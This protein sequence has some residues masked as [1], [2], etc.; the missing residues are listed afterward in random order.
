M[1]V[2]FVTGIGIGL[3]VFSNMVMLTVYFNDKLAL[4]S[5]LCMVG[6]G[7]GQIILP[8][9]FNYLLSVLDAR[10]AFLVLGASML[11]VLIGAALQRPQSYYMSIGSN[12]S[13]FTKPSPTKTNVMMCG[14][15]RH[16]GTDAIYDLGQAGS[17]TFTDS[18]RSTHLHLVDMA[19][20]PN[21]V[22][23]SSAV[24]E[25][26]R[27]L[28][29]ANNTCDVS[30][31]VTDGRITGTNKIGPMPINVNRQKSELTLSVVCLP[32]NTD[33]HEIPISTTSG[34]PNNIIIEERKSQPFPIASPPT[35]KEATCRMCSASTFP[36]FILARVMTF[37]SYMM[38]VFFLA[39]YASGEGL[40]TTQINLVL[41]A[42]GAVD[43][44]SRPLHGLLVSF[45]HI[46]SSLFVGCVVL[47][48]GAINGKYYVQSGTPQCTYIYCPVTYATSK[49]GTC[50]DVS[51]IL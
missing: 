7:I 30:E 29:A 34:K 6:S 39:P 31:T 8:Y 10:G 5:G 18:C 16:D 41:T 1:Q 20:V 42:F 49:L 47:V 33:G 51:M 11:H 9:W 15:K 23:A 3:L 48:A 14:T 35:F 28:I 13:T 4:V 17:F 27:E 38:A 46:D 40:S 36:L 19:Y 32:K 44:A 43:I 21:D 12:H 22:P 37:A 2:R 50:A 26:S 45:L 24:P 25:V